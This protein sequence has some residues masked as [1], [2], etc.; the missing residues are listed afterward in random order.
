VIA[1]AVLASAWNTFTS[2]Q[3][4]I[5]GYRIS[6]NYNEVYRKSVAVWLRDNTPQDARVGE[7]FLGVGAIGYYSGRYI[8]DAGGLADHTI[9]TYWA[10]DGNPAASSKETFAYF[11]AKNTSYVIDAPMREHGEKYQALV[12]IANA[13]GNMVWAGVS[14]DTAVVYRYNPSSSQNS[15][16]S[17]EVYTPAPGL[18]IFV[19]QAQ[20]QGKHVVAAHGTGWYPFEP[21]GK[22]RWA[23]SPASLYVYSESAQEV[24][25]MLKPAY[26]LFD[27]KNRTVDRGVL[28]VDLNG[29][30]A[31]K[32]AMQV[33]EPLTIT[34][35]LA[36][37]WNTIYLSSATGNF[38]MDQVEGGN[39]D[40]RTFS[41]ALS[42]ISFF[43][44]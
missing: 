16:P 27:G 19:D 33:G 36:K 41:F 3:G 1:L 40:P 17:S 44:R 32:Y 38:K 12:A 25:C 43:T 8:V 6:S 20:Q 13:E 2:A 35:P 4:S 30:P 18:D 10:A 26:A 23:T 34:V 39:A 37:G 24:D 22:A 14:F 7:N 28:L 29:L 31:Q 21:Q 15:S 5:D 42:S 11:D 9:L